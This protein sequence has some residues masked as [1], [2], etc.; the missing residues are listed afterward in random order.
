MRKRFISLGKKIPAAVLAAVMVLTLSVTGMALPTDKQDGYYIPTIYDVQSIE[1][2]WADYIPTVEKAEKGVTITYNGGDV[3]RA[4][5]LVDKYNIDGLSLHFDNLT[6]N[7]GCSDAVRFTIVLATSHDGIGHFRLQ[8]DTSDGTVRYIQVSG[9]TPSEPIITSDLLKYETLSKNEFSVSFNS[10]SSGGI[11]C[12]VKVGEEVLTGELPQSYIS[13][14]QQASDT[15]QQSQVLVF[16]VDSSSVKIA[17]GRNYGS[18]AYY[19]SLDL[20]GIDYDPYTLPTLGAKI[21]TERSDEHFTSGKIALSSASNGAFPRALLCKFNGVDIGGRYTSGSSYDIDGLALRFSE[22]SKLEGYES[23]AAKLAVTFTTTP[24]GSIG[25]V[26]VMIDSSTGNVYYWG[27]TV[28]ANAQQI[29]SNEALLYDNLAGKDIEMLF[30]ID[31]SSNLIC[32]IT[33]GETVVTATMPA[34]Y[35]TNLG[36][37]KANFEVGPGNSACYFTVKFTGVRS[38]KRVK[39]LD[40]ENNIIAQTNVNAG[41]TVIPPATTA[42]AGSVILGWKNLSDDGVYGLNAH[43]IEDHSTYRLLT[44]KIGDANRDDVIDSNDVVAVR[45]DMIGAESAQFTQLLDVNSDGEI[46]ILDL[47][48]LKK[49]VVGADTS[50]LG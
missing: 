49:Y 24:G 22:L 28:G 30:E 27:G 32:Y 31:N 44:G 50:V 15:S 25:K 14:C 33:V 7:E 23:E 34:S 1:T 35:F 8:F 19:F 2:R 20:T 48:R 11:T 42:E 18:D 21:L 6:K 36:A 3:G 39:Y 16:N 17:P 41:K 5:P 12:T 37:T 46:N 29:A 13:S 38:T 40:P 26:R 9:R 10:N 47:V 43:I 45:K 4:V